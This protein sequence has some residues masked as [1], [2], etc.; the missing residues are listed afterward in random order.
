VRV[1]ES[2]FKRLVSEKEKLRLHIKEAREAQDTAMKAQ[3]KAWEDMRVA[4][5][6]EERLRQQMD[7]LD[8]RAAEA[9]SVEERGIEEQ[10]REEAEGAFLPE[11]SSEGLAL[12]L[13]P[14]TWGAFEGVPDDFW[15]SAE[16]AGLLPLPEMPVR[17]DS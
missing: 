2:E 9:I 12:S 1:T 11:G 7:L 16:A 14:H 4:R 17:P 8:R 10:E 5:A 15:E 13:S 3:E 6:R